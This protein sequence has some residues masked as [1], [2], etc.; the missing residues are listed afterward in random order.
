MAERLTSTVTATGNLAEDDLQR[1]ARLKQIN[2]RIQ[3]LKARDDDRQQFLKAMDSHTAQRLQ[4]RL[5]QFRAEAAEREQARQRFEQRL[6]HP[7]FEVRSCSLLRFISACVSD[8]RLL[9]ATVHRSASNVKNTAFC[10][11]CEEW[12]LIGMLPCSYNHGD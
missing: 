5:Q 2:A 4:Q 7:V 12:C 10:Q 11:L 9:K 1:L 3:E 8:S 6:K